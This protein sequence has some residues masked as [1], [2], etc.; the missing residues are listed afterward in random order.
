MKR[1]R[2]LLNGL[3]LPA[4]KLDINSVYTLYVQH[5]YT[6]INI[7]IYTNEELHILKHRCPLIGHTEDL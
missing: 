4:S 3:V 1:K 2:S 5:M 6:L 7:Q